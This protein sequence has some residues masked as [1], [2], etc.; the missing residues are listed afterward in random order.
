MESAGISADPQAGL[1]MAV[2]CSGE[3]DL[4]DDLLG[5]LRGGTTGPCCPCAA[6]RGSLE[7]RFGARGSVDVKLLLQHGLAAAL[8]GLAQPHGFSGALQLCGSGIVAA[9]QHKHHVQRPERSILV[10]MPRPSS[11]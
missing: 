8:Y 7:P 10:R 5:A 1:Y 6:V 9:Q 3:A 11:R 2:L 4:A